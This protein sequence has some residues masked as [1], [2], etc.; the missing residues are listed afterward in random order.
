MVEFSISYCIYLRNTL[1][2][3]FCSMVEH[4]R[5]ANFSQFFALGTRDLFVFKFFKAV[6][7]NLHYSKA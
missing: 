3:L 1:P 2:F 7:P 4:G 5:L 6:D